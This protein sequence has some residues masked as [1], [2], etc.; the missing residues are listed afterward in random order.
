MILKFGAWAIFAAAAAAWFEFSY[1]TLAALA[2]E[3][4]ARPESC[5]LRLASFE[6]LAAE[7]ISVCISRMMAY[8]RL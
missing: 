7:F 1:C 5:W 3:E 8:A 2:P 4:A 6:A